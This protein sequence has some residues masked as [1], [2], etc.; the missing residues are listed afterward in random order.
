MSILSISA[1]AQLQRLGRLLVVVVRAFASN[2]TLLCLLAVYVQP[3]S[4]FLPAMFNVDNLWLDK[5]LRLLDGKGWTDVL[6]NLL[7]FYL[8]KL[9]VCYMFQIANRQAGKRGGSVRC[10]QQMS[11]DLLH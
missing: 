10:V 9:I 5:Y 11:D 2:C 3:A 6:E 8:S 4:A 7:T 1:W